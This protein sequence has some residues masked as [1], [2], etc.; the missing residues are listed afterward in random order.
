[1]KNKIVEKIDEYL[2]ESSLSRVWR[3]NEKYDCAAM[4]AFRKARE[5]GEGE[6]YTN[7]E[8]KARNKSLLAKIQ[9]K[10]YGATSLSG[11]YPEGGKVTK[12]ISFFIVDLNETGNL[13]KD[14]VK[15][16]K[17]FEQDSVLFIPKGAIQNKVKAFLIGT[18]NCPNNW[19]GMGK[20]E[21]FNKGGKLGYSSTVYTSYV[22][23][24]PFIFEDVECNH[25]PPGNGYGYIS[26]NKVAEKDWVELI[27][28]D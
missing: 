12:E 17:E 22:N 5:C 19:L 27:E 13:Q 10:G 15:W 21:I 24:R 8:N 7:K 25:Y 28:E 20:K 14:L 6:V 26:L 23:D 11:A 16:G 1:M 2:N 18:N 3:H 9:A 4:T